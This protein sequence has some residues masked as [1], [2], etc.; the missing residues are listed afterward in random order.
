MQSGWWPPTDTVVCLLLMSLVKS[1]FG[2]NIVQ[3]LGLQHFLNPRMGCTSHLS[4]WKRGICLVP[5]LGGLDCGVHKW[6]FSHN[7]IFQGPTAN[8]L[9]WWW[10]RASLSKGGTFALFVGLVLGISQITN[11]EFFRNRTTNCPAPARHTVW[12]CHRYR[13]RR[14][15]GQHQRERVSRAGEEAKG[16]WWMV[17][18]CKVIQG[19][20]TYPL[21]SPI[22]CWFLL[23]ILTTHLAPQR[24]YSASTHGACSS[25]SADWTGAQC[26]CAN[27]DGASDWCIN[28][29]WSR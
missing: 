19:T 3:F 14:W 13:W 25:L 28:V 27:A 16:R 24:P 22:H 17:P 18:V 23:D 9:R 7:L 1:S 11:W 5:I 4:T 20:R 12:D 29:G 2:S 15:R 8:C 21:G 26:P 6:I 10:T